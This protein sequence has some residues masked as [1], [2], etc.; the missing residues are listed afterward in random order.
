M[1]YK[2]GDTLKVIVYI[3]TTGVTVHYR[4]MDESGNYAAELDMTEISDG[5]YYLTF[6]PD[7][8][9]KWGIRIYCVLPEFDNAFSWQIGDGQEGNPDDT[10]TDTIMG[11][12]G[13]DA[14]MGDRSM[15][16]LLV[17]DGPAVFPVAA[18]AGNDVSI[19]E[20]IRYI[21]ETLIGY[22]GTTSIADKLTAARATNLD[23]L[24]FN[25]K[26][27]IGSTGAALVSE[28]Y[29][30]GT[31]AGILRGMNSEIQI[32]FIIPDLYVA[33]MSVDNTAIR[34]QLLKVGNVVTIVQPDALYYPDYGMYNLIVLGS[35]QTNA[36]VV[37]NLADL[38]SHP[39]AP[40]LNCDSVTAAYMGMGTVAADKL[41]W[42]DIDCED[43]IE[44]SILG[45]VAGWRG[46]TALES[47]PNTV[48]T[49]CVHTQMDM[50]DAD[51]T[52]TVYAYYNMNNSTDVGLALI[53]R[54][55]LD[56]TIGVDKDGADVNQT[57]GFYGAAYSANSFTEMGENTL[58]LLASLMALETTTGQYAS[59]L[60]PVDAMR[61]TDSAALA[62]DWTSALATI[63]ANFT[64]LRIGYIDQLDFD[65]A[66]AIGAIPTTAMRGTDS[67]A[68]ASAW[69]AGLATV[70]GNYTALRA[71]YLDQLDFDL[72]AAI[73]A[74]PTTMVGTNGAALAASW[75]AGLATIL[76]NFSAV[77]I[78]YLDELDFDLAAAIA[79]IPTTMIGTNNA[80]LATQIGSEFDGTPDLYD[81]LVTG[82]IPV[83][84][85]AA[86]PA[87]MISIAQVLRQIYDEVAA[88]SGAAMR[89]TDGAA[90]V[91]S[92]WDAGLATILDN[93]T[94]LRIGYLDE[95]D[96]DLQA[97]IGAIGGGDATEAKQDT[98]I[99]ALVVI[100]GIVDTLIARLTALRAGYLDELAPANIPADI[101]T[102]LGRLSAVRAGYLDELAP[103]N[104]PSDIDDITAAIVVID[105]FHDVAVADAVTNL[106]M[107]DLLGNKADT[108]TNSINATSSIMRYIKGMLGA[109]WTTESI[110]GIYD[111]VIG[112]VNSAGPGVPTQNSMLDYI[113]NID[114]G[115]TFDR[116]TG[117]LEAL[118]LAI[119][120]IGGGVG[121][122]PVGAGVQQT[123]AFSITAALNA[124]VTAVATV[125]TQPVVIDSIV[126]HA[127]TAAHADMTT[128][129]IVGGVGQVIT[130]ISTEDAIEAKL[131]A[132]DKQVW[133]IGAVRMAVGKI[134]YIDLQG[135]GATAA[136][137]TVTITYHAEV[138][139]GLL[140]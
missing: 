23:Q 85:V 43:E 5:W 46:V 94:A 57:L 127:D 78:G 118:A 33:G 38:K 123:K 83:W 61:G 22:E 101:D 39:G 51:I 136:D 121:L 71:G 139:G 99:A 77:R 67:A 111:E 65:L 95:L 18:A 104:L 117:S 84:P 125:G 20:V 35:E 49:S 27:A 74:I 25:L 86:A 15:F 37:A 54:V 58:F 114:P 105:A 89:G 36:W 113:M 13:T 60:V 72:A 140:A 59:G 40:V 122:S 107:S 14:E 82:G 56:G 103:A 129:A 137:L 63:L 32:L 68:L 42:Q 128:C 108:A 44:G 96:F 64:A 1:G 11:K 79:A 45:S 75:T 119:A 115:Q 126:L 6:A 124:G 53:R 8:V 17:G 24:D 131:D 81:V 31:I 135:V 109:G 55:Q 132:I 133:W 4:V 91:V 100:D 138:S 130:F 41:D 69:T 50:S 62:A 47:G 28:F 34:T 93:F 26:E 10:T 19:A 98:M 102:L 90:L 2:V 88:I 21:Q 70:L 110:I 9:G 73:A 97:A 92:G 134:I 3:A 16:D 80:V 87:N 29:D 76:A 106:V 12:I 116:T 120:A 112:I 52:E 66:A 7:A 48:T 30:D